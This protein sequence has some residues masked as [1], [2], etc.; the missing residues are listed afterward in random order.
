MNSDVYGEGSHCALCQ[1]DHAAFRVQFAADRRLAR[2]DA[3]LIPVVDADLDGSR[4]PL[5][6]QPPYGTCTADAHTGR[7]KLSCGLLDC[8]TAGPN[9]V[10]R[11]TR[12][13]FDWMDCQWNGA[14]FEGQQGGRKVERPS[15]VA[16]YA[17]P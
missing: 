6:A 15:A 7:A 4:Y 9:D 3:V 12:Q 13:H 1:P 8:L 2:L 17:R 16:G 5:T 14:V 11:D 10:V